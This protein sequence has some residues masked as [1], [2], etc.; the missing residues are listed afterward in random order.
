MEWLKVYRD[1][2]DGKGHKISLHR[3]I[4]LKTQ[5]MENPPLP[6]HPKSMRPLVL[7]AKQEVALA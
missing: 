7:E 5:P 2:F 6:R 3:L 4:R 1:G